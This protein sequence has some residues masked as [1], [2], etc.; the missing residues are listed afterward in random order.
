MSRT[1]VYKIY[2]PSLEVELPEK[3]KT[4]EDAEKAAIGMWAKVRPSGEYMHP[5]YE[6]VEREEQ[7]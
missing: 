6:V 2:L 1:K 4:R 3:Y 7:N 5:D